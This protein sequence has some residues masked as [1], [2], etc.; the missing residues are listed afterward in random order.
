MKKNKLVPIY[1]VDFLLFGMVCNMKE[2]KLAWHLNNLFEIQLSRQ[3]D[4]KIEY[5]NHSSIL[6]SSYTHQS[7]TLRVDLIQ[8][9]LIAQDGI[10]KSKFLL[11]ELA[12]FDYFLK[13]TDQTSEMTPENVIVVIRESTLVQYVAKL[14]FGTLKSKDN[15]LY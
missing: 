9:K 15:L 5:A 13:I 7:E 11:P 8:N 4:M 3:D 14:N 1:E 6:F 2:Y 12:Q 10:I